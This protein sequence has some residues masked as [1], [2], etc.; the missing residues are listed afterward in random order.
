M[1]SNS[2]DLIPE[3]QPT[4]GE[5]VSD[6]KEEEI[7][8]SVVDALPPQKNIDDEKLTNIKEKDDDDDDLKKEK[9][10]K[11]KKQKDKATT[12]SFFKLFRFATPLDI[13]FMVVG[14][15]ASLALGAAIPV[16]T[17]LFAGFI[18]TFFVFVLQQNT[19]Y[20]ECRAAAEQQLDDG[21]RN[22]ALQ[23]I[24]LGVAVFAAGYL[25][26]CLWMIAG[27]RQANRLRSL[28]YSAILR[29][30]ITFFDTVST[31]DVTT[32]ISG[33]ISLFQEGISEK[34]G[35]ILQYAAT[36]FGGFI[37]GFIKGWKL[38]LVLCT[39]FPLMAAA[40]GFMAR[41]LSR[42]TSEGQ[43]AYA[44]AGGVAEQVFS[45]I[46]TVTAFGGQKREIERYTEQLRRAYNLGKRKAY[47][48]GAGLG[49][50]T[51]I[52]FGCYGLAFW[53]GSILVVNHETT[54]PDIL[55]VFFAVFIGAF[56]VGNAAPH[57]TAVSNS[58]GAAAKLFEV[59]DRVPIIDSTS[60]NG[61]IIQ[62]SSSQGRIEFKNV[63]FHYPTRPDVQ[64]LKN[65]NLIIEPGQTV[66]L[67][68]SSGSGK[69]TII[70]LLERFYDPINGS[71]LLD[72]I[73][74]KDINIKS[75]RRQIG[76]VGQE[77][78]LFA[79]SIKVNIGWG[80]DPMESEP[81]LS[82]IMDACKKSNAHDFIDELPKK[83]DTVVGEKGSLLS[84][85]QKQRIAIARALIKDPRI[86]LLDEATSALDTESER[87][88][89]EALDKAATN[90]TS[91]II[92]HRLSTIKHAD[93]IVVMK[94]GEIVE[95]G[96]HD[97]LISKQGVYFGLVRAQELET[98]KTEKKTDE[99]DEDEE[100]SSSSNEDTSV[101]IDEKKHK[102]HL[103]K[104]STK[105][106]TIKSIK[107]DEEIIKEDTEKKLLQKTPLARVFK[108]CKP[109]YGLMFIGCIG[110]A[111][112]GS[113]MPLFSLVFSSILDAFSRTDQLDQL[114]K[115]ANFW[116][117]CFAILAVVSFLANFAQLS[118]F[119]LS[120]ERLTKRLRKLTFEALMRQEIA[121]FDD[122][123][124]GTG[125]LTSKLA[126]DAT[127]VEGLSGGLM[128][129]VIQNL[130]SLTLGFGLAF[131][132]GWKLTL[133]ILAASPAVVIAGF[134]EMRAMTGFGS[135]TRAA[136]EGTGQIVQQSVSNMRT[137]AALTREE[138][139]KNTYQDALKEPHKIAIKGSLLSSFGFGTSQGI[140]YFIWSLAFWYGSKLVETGE[141]DLQ[142]MLRVM[143]AVVFTA[144][145]LGQMSTFAPDV[146]KAK[147]AALSIFEIL[148]RKSL[149]NP[150]DNEGKDRP[151]PVLGDS[152]FHSVH[153]KYPARPNVPILRGLDLSIYSGKTIALV[154]SSGSGKSTVISLLLRFY[155][156]DSGEIEVEGVN[157]KQWNLEY[158]RANMA[159]VGQEPVLFD[160]T[161]EQ[162]IAYG[163]EGCTREEIEEAA[164]EANIH[165]FITSL[166][167][168]YDTRVGEKG[169]QL[170]GGQKQR[171]AIARALIRSPKI[172]L[173]DE[174]TSALDSESEKV[175]QNALN[176]ASKG[177]T[178]LTIAHRLST[179]QNADLILVCKKGKIV[180]SGK[181]FDLI[182][183]KGLYYELVNKQ[184]LIKKND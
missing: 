105:G 43:D 89:Q 115:A 183:Q 141:Y 166:P 148:D 156:A 59:I 62:K 163:K 174:A 126:V 96:Q 85:G 22:Y 67:V 110:A 45:G 94:K 97:E 114:Q 182:N 66:A 33:D 68:G 63:S 12:V 170:S 19:C 14:S 73:D 83:Y 165:N 50:L 132:F 87:L 173:L 121:Y 54:G 37:I 49:V 58:M 142:R 177:R 93:K 130:C 101:I 8:F 78:V 95:I 71:I 61:Q 74:I 153:F 109:E 88:V 152:S 84:G 118:M 51:F 92:A 60:S 20:P 129:T 112:N 143:F 13:I 46:R 10:I 176:K 41:A 31:G 100:L 98:K 18:N 75:L 184:T 140:L 172:L 48:S 162:N 17:I 122:E 65:F 119:M 151:A 150:T 124:N 7:D 147:V 117:M 128:G 24:G 27:E 159:L 120:G 42:G 2:Q 80:G 57:F 5:S 76:L 155:D 144:V 47:V 125:V 70:S 39:V 134:L 21:V 79:E 26:M 113:V 55:N 64:I 135:K 108:L 131:G 179:I 3:Q 181:H 81:N 15:I 167:D 99:D 145:S 171:V 11:Q 164:K 154:G 52:M 72:G 90:R 175:V 168:G 53:Y 158:L 149:I 28:Y 34:V 146:A 9:K 1:S 157:L 133:V 23:F 169:T 38:T 127:K 137:I 35:Q 6:V 44:A 138:T 69:S 178:T 40:G 4:S 116:S 82:D 123:K 136:Y 36:F 180:E 102:L 32:R 107:T 111:V 91:I 30:D 106:S 77:P 161:I 56:S 25:Q 16:M 103:R 104:I 86:L 160:L 29:Q 139:F